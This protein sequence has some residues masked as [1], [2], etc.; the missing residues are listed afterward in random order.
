MDFTRK[1]KAAPLKT[2]AKD[3]SE[4][5]EKLKQLVA[6]AHVELEEIQAQEEAKG[7]PVSN[8]SGEE[9]R[10]NQ[11]WAASESVDPSVD[12]V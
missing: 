8:A 10:T 1:K 6:K 9:S 12:A 2:E 3:Q 4:Q 7:A 11:A 5:I